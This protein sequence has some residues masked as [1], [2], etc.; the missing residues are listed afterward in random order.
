MRRELKPSY[1]EAERAAK[2]VR[3]LLV[4][5]GSH[6]IARQQMPVGS[7]PDAR[8]R[9]PQ[10]ATWRRADVEIVRK[11]GD[12]AAH[13]VGDPLLLQQA[14]LNIIINAEH[15]IAER[16]SAR[17]IEIATGLGR[18]RDSVDHHDPRLRARASAPDVL[19]R[20]FDPFFTTKEVGQGT[21]LGLAIT[22][23]IV[24]EHGGTITAGTAPDGGAL[25]TD[26]LPAAPWVIKWSQVPSR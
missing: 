13:R 9:E 11:Q 1:H 18:P 7:P 19:P 5:T 3:N 20:I 23:G 12:E 21:G 14:L 24:Q 22:Y 25:F 6:R 2:I 26:R 17:R 16:R 8:D 10:A 15:A 4:F